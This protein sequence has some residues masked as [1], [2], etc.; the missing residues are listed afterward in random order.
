MSQVRSHFEDRHIGPDSDQ[1]AAMLK[2]IGEKDLTSFIA[3][4]V[5]AN[6]A[7]SQKLDEVLPKAISEEAALAEL[8]E[9]ASKNATTRS[10]VGIGF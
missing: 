6:I 10:L 2:D 5:P 3:R 7:I 9:L 4:V 8:R 1:I